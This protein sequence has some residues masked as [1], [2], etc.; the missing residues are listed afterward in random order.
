M[1]AYRTSSFVTALAT[2][3]VSLTGA[4]FLSAAAIPRAVCGVRLAQDAPADARIWIG[5]AREIEDYLRTVPFV[6]LEDL[7]VGVTKPKK[8]TLP[9]GGPVGFLAW[10][11]IPPGMYSGSWE[12]YKSEIAAYEVDKLVGLNMVPPTVEKIYRGEHGA[13]VMWASP[14]K[15]FKDFGGSGAPT[16]PANKQLA[17]NRQLVEAKMFD[18]L[19]GNTDPNLGNWL[20][21]PAWNLLLI[22][23]S[24]A[25]TTGKDMTHVMTRIDPD[26]W[27]RI[28]ALTEETLRPA[29]GN[30]IAGGQLKAVIQRRDKMRQIVDQLVKDKGEAFVF[31][32]D[33]RN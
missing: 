22:D 19:I 11:A 33:G 26:L 27:A 15:N 20:A 1:R 31:M 5:R 18:N 32:R 2:A 8:A 6:K 21:D 24:R 25:F 14:T 13:A 9:P 10:K 16:P 4:V 30:L 23:H 29:I 28:L 12:S 17:W 3:A 7:S